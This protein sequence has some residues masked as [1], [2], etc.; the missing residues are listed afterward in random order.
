MSGG[1]MKKPLR[2]AAL[3]ALAAGVWEKRPGRKPGGGLMNSAGLQAEF[4]RD[5][6]GIQPSF[7]AGFLQSETPRQCPL[8]SRFMPFFQPD[9]QPDAFSSETVLNAE[10]VVVFVFKPQVIGVN[11]SAF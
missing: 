5:S 6:A 7:R 1:R 11:E 8:S 3:W 4:I 9:F 10:A 2:P